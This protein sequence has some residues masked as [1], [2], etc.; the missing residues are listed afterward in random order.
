MLFVLISQEKSHNARRWPYMPL[1]WTHRARRRKRL[2]LMMAGIWKPPL[3]MLT[4]CPDLQNIALCWSQKELSDRLFP[5]SAGLLVLVLRCYLRMATRV[6]MLGHQWR[7]RDKEPGKELNSKDTSIYRLS[8]KLKL[9]VEQWDEGLAV[10]VLPQ[11]FTRLNASAKRKEEPSVLSVL[12][13]A[14]ASHPDMADIHHALAF[15]IYSHL[16]QTH[17]DTHRNK[18]LNPNE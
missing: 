3:T 11:F 13:P 18:D 17:K 14:C 15:I 7:H 6:W 5:T 2:Q 9:Q 1:H 16:A 12:E 10:E 8:W 4:T